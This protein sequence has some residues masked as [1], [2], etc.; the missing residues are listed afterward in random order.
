MNE[1][2][3]DSTEREG[4]RDGRE[5]ESHPGRMMR[6]WNYWRGVKACGRE[7]VFPPHWTVRKWQMRVNC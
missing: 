5:E 3:N 2:I 7:R 6:E 1:G 4:G